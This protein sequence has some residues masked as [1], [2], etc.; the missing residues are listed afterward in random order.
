MA[1]DWVTPCL[2]ALLI[3]PTNAA[4]SQTADSLYTTPSRGMYV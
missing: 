2:L 1:R 3:S 4:P